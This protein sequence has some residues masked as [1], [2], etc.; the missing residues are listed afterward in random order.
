MA[1]FSLPQ[2]TRSTS[3]L[4]PSNPRAGCPKP[5]SRRPPSH[6]AP[7]GPLSKPPRVALAIRRASVLR[8]NRIDH[9]RQQWDRSI[10]RLPTNAGVAAVTRQILLPAPTV[11][12]FDVCARRIH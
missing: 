6:S 11:S 9:R 10:V 12:L 1:P 2:L 4:S 5:S 3:S 8:V 7:R